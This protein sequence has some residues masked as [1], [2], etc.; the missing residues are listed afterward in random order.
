MTRTRQLAEPA[1]L[2]GGGRV[3][4]RLDPSSPL[5]RYEARWFTAEGEFSGHAVLDENGEALV[6]GNGA[7]AWLLDWTAALLRLI[8]RDHAAGSPWPRRLTRWR[9]PH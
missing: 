7:P 1:Q 8:A 4:L 6:E 3:E 9:Q 2:T 5:V